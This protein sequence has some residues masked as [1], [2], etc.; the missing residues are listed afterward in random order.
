MEDGST[1][2]PLLVKASSFTLAVVLPL[3]WELKDA[4]STEGAHLRVTGAGAGRAG[5]GS[6]GKEG[7]V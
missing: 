5:V 6:G 7:A 4:Q 2:S 1:L 3:C